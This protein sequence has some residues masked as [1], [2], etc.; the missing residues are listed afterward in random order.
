MLVASIKESSRDEDA[1]FYRKQL[2]VPE[3]E[4]IGCDQDAMAVFVLEGELVVWGMLI[5]SLVEDPFLGVEGPD[6]AVLFRP[7]D[8]LAGDKRRSPGSKS[9]LSP[10]AQA[11]S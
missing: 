10:G 11:L 8:D 6:G 5:E 2:P 9:G 1:P 7:D 4:A 3:P